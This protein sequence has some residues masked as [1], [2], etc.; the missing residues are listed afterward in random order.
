MKRPVAVAVAVAVALAIALASG[1][2][3][4]DDDEALAAMRRGVAASGRGDA[5]EALRE[6]E[7]A[8]RAAP[9]A[10]MPYRY[11]AETLLSIGRYREA[12]ENLEAYLA[13]RPDV[14][15]AQ[16]VRVLIARV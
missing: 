1:K 16:D 10:N 12:V 13:K 7:A 15:D 11:A 9:L 3:A 2:A 4:A 6:Y 8:K 14:G 5:E